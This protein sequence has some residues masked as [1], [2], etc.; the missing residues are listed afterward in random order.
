MPETVETYFPQTNPNLQRFNFIV[1]AV[2]ALFAVLWLVLI[3][4]APTLKANGLTQAA[5]AIYTP[6]A[7]LCHQ[8]LERSFYLFNEAFAV[9]ARCFG[10]YFG[11]AFGVLAYPL[12][13]SLGDLQPLPRIWLLLSPVPTTIDWA[14][15]IFGIWQ[16]THFSRFFTASVL[17]VGIAFFLI[18][19][20]IEVSRFFSQ[21]LTVSSQ[22]KTDN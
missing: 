19:G 6:F 18:P 11:V 1:W 5:N 20:I 9:C 13:R 16:N 15:G 22:R 2:T 3:I 12:F 10:V 4:A 7:Y 8:Q 17:G 14:L 21:Q